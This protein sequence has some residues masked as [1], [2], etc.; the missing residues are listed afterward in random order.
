MLL[1][2]QVLKLGYSGVSLFIGVIDSTGWLKYFCTMRLEFEINRTIWKFSVTVI[3]IVI[4]RTG[5]DHLFVRNNIFNI[6]IVGI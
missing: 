2:G 4:Y 3:E 1:P 6:L 5:I